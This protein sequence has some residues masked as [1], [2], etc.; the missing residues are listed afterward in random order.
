MGRRRPEGSGSQ[1]HSTFEPLVALLQ[2]EL[3]A[4]G[5][6]YPRL[7]ARTPRQFARYYL[8]VVQL[9]EAQVAAGDDHAPMSRTWSNTVPIDWSMRSTIAAWIA[10]FVA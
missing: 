6:V 5:I 2:Q 4:A 8:E 1:Q 3:D 7:R 10:I 9:L